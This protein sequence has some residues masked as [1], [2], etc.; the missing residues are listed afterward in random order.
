M[1]VW[2]S[3]L[4]SGNSNRLCQFDI[5]H[6]WLFKVGSIF[7]EVYAWN[8]SFSQKYQFNQICWN[9]RGNNWR[10]LKTLTL[11]NVDPFPVLDTLSS[12]DRI[13]PDRRRCHGDDWVNF[14]IAPMRNTTLSL[15]P[16]RRCQCCCCCC[17]C[18]PMHQL[19]TRT[20]WWNL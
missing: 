12:D 7:R 9:F 3:K 11:A 5:L 14:A 20:L 8:L 18:W 1:T 17:C 16:F 13:A 2:D 6:I 15:C 4:L 10:K 19:L